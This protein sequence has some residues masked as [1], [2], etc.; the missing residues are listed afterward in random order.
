MRIRKELQIILYLNILVLGIITYCTFGILLVVFDDSSPESLQNHELNPSISESIGVNIDSIPKIPKIIHQ[1]Y[2]TENIP[3][4]WKENQQKCI[5]LHP[6][7]EYKLWT[8]EKAYEFIKANYSW[9]L[10]TFEHYKFP[11]QRFNAIKYFALYH[12]GGVYIDL[13][14]SC[15][16]KVD[17]LLNSVAFVRKATPLGIS[18]DIMGSCVKHPFFLKLINSLQRYNKDWYI[19]YLTI[20]GSTG[21]LF[22]SIVWK[23]YK[24][25]S[26][27][28][29][30]NN[31]VRILRPKDYLV[32]KDAYFS[33]TK[34]ATWHEDDAVFKK[35]LGNHILSCITAGFVL[36]FA[37]LY[38][39]YI[40]YCWLCSN[41]DLF[42]NF[43]MGIWK[44]LNN[45][46]LWVY[47][48]LTRNRFCRAAIGDPM[49]IINYGNNTND[50]VMTD[51]P[52]SSPTIPTKKRKTTP[53]F[54][55][56]PCPSRTSSDLE[57]NGKKDD[58]DVTNASSGLQ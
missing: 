45:I 3:E 43:Y 8:D 9:F 44:T 7:Y 24:I 47:Q 6:D 14:D 17:P 16:R 48:K 40:I 37:I 56:L 54:S 5:Y 22:V 25:W 1:V 21:P 52:V 11:M 36:T 46:L 57:K 38:S 4:Q 28:I 34:G 19:P 26:D 2:R 30:E 29:M 35:S 31:V 58:S 10:K 39:Q 20:L 53:G 49:V 50:I 18:N 41:S 15:H 55:F 33:I 32:H 27:D 12:F 51:I 23:K 42:R 13:D